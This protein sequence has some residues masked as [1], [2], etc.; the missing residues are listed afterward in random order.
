MS[1]HVIKILHKAGE[2]YLVDPGHQV[3]ANGD[4][5]VWENKTDS[6]AEVFPDPRLFGW[7]KPI[8]VPGKKQSSAQE[9]RSGPGF[10]PYACECRGEYAEGGSHPGVIVK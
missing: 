3:A 5:L 2:G 6:A 8:T 10:Y 1:N 7:G 4:V 9:I